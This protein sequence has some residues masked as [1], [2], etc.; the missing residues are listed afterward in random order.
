M[1]GVKRQNGGEV[2]DA[3]SHIQRL[4]DETGVTVIGALHLGKEAINR[5]GAMK[6]LDS[7]EY[8]NLARNVIGINDLPD[9][10]Q[11][12]D[13]LTDPARGRRKVLAVLKANAAIPGPP[14]VWSRARDAEVAWHGP[15]TVSFDESFANAP[16]ATA[17]ES[18]K[19]WLFTFLSG[20]MQPQTAVETE[21]TAAG[22]SMRTLKRAKAELS[23]AS[24]KDRSGP[25]Y[26]KLP[27]GTPRRGNAS[28]EAKEATD[29]GQHPRQENVAPLAP[30]PRHAAN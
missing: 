28:R 16:P 11:P 30:F 19:G 25:W 26:W 10:H 14:L 4:I 17:R 12:E 9:A 29:G 8:V 1:P 5:R 22:F 3:L 27:D 24:I 7:V 21:G 13:V 2:R 20:G 6:V 15:S 23:V 18:A